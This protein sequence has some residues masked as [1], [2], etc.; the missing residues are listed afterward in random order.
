MRVSAVQM[1]MRFCDPDYNFARAAELIVEA[2][3]ASPDVIMLPET[4]NTG[5]F[6]REN[7]EALC[8]ED[9]SRVKGEIGILAKNLHVNIVAGSVS[10]L[11]DGKVYN[12]AT[13]FDREGNCV[14]TY[15]KTHLFTPMG[16]HEFYQLGEAPPAPF[17]LDGVRCGLIICY[18]VRFPELT[19]TATLKG[20]DVFFMVSQWPNARTA[21][22]NALVEARAIENQMFF[23][24]CNSCG[25][26]G[27]VRY[28]GNSALIDPWGKV[29]CRAGD[30]QETI[31]A[32]FDPG[33]VRE[34]RESIN[35]FRD[36]RPEIYDI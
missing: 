14:A 29:L 34:I 11:R 9:A 16:E 22:L 1:N 27:D 10:N 18:D 20:V 24:C 23:A 5:F 33:V 30:A 6:P 36:R 13:V 25:S 8:D 26:A 32:E 4:W 35:V 21:H 12:T 2:S 19:R 15:D 31:T 3:K 17:L 7:L 28:G